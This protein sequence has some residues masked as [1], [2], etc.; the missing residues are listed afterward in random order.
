MHA[1][2]RRALVVGALVGLACQDAPTGSPLGTL[3][4]ESHTGPGSTGP[5][6]HSQ[7]VKLL[8]NVARSGEHTQSD[9][10]FAGRHAFAG[11]YAGF[12]VLDV[13]D[14]QAPWVVGD[15][16]CNGAQGDVSVWG[17]LL[18]LSVDQAQT[19][20]ACDSEDAFPD[21]TTFEGIRIFDVGDPASPRHVASVATDC[22]SHTNTV[23][24]DLANGRV[25]V[26]VSSYP[27]SLFS[28]GPNCALPHG[29][30]SIVHVPLADPAA[31]TVTKY[32]LDAAT[33]AMPA[34]YTACHDITVFVQLQRAAAACLTEMQLWDIAD[35]A[36]PRFLWR[37]DNAAVN[38]ANDDIWHSTAFS[39]D[40][41][42]VAVG[43]ES[44]GGA[45]ARCVDPTDQQGRIWFLSVATGQ[46][47]GSYKIP[48]VE[49]GP[50]TS[51]NFNFIPQPGGRK[52]LVSA[53]Y[54]GGTTVVDV[55]RL[56]TGASAA[57]AEVGFYRPA[58]GR[59]WSSYWYNGFVY[60]NDMLRGLDVMLVSDNARLSARKLP[61]MNPQTQLAVIP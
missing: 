4:H 27:G 51:H 36:N 52:V 49:T 3:L 30:I 44:G 8:A 34:G 38:V 24:P 31:A 58:G 2:P 9:L 59:A 33:Q 21:A 19:G 7:N 20:T 41:R 1:L 32:Q 13:S 40:G 6:L 29:F 25:L 26:Y 53:A 12:R 14:P 57:Q 15:V 28:R 5:D 11:S 55:D 10:A 46:A 37:F 45:D 17:N 23:V 54:T 35:P 47:L 18:F 42:V 22:G 56:L 50:C 61:F 48:R 60:V 39:W 16:A 43:D